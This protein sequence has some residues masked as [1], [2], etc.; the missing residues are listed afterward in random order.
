[1]TA[2]R[3]KDGL[4]IPLLDTRGDRAMM[5]VRIKMARLRFLRVLAVAV[6]AAAGESSGQYLEAV[7]P[8]G[9]TP[10]WIVWSPA[11]NKVY[12]SNEQDASITVISGETNEVIATI[13]VG[14]YPS[15][16]CLNADGSKVYCARGAEDRLVV[17]DAVADTVLKTLGIPNY[18]GHTVFNSTMN[19]LYI[20]CSDDP[21][22]RIAVLDATADTLLRYI[23]VRGVGRLL[24]HPGTNR[25]FSYTV[26]GADTVKVIDCLTDE[27]VVRLPVPT[28]PN[29]LGTWC[30][31]P[32]NGS[33]YL[34]SYR[35]VCA[36][37]PL[38]DSVTAVIPGGGD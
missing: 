21:V 31:N 30:Y 25:V 24:W 28:G 20:S 34:A 14:D 4:E 26:W 8:T 7:V 23:P 22:F 6:C 2:T 37:T 12:C 17:I 9:D 3:Q 38:G 11:V 32:V 29:A 15:F 13:Q 36:L 10:T 27:V 33:V 19:K 1:L 18:P 35:V 16:L 5:F